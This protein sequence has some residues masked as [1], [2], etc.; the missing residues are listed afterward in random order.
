MADVPAI[1]RQ[2]KVWRQRYARERTKVLRRLIRRFNSGHVH[3]G[4]VMIEE[5]LMSFG[6]QC[7]KKGNSYR[8]YVDDAVVSTLYPL[9]RTID[10]ILR[11]DCDCTALPGGKW[12]FC[13]RE[14]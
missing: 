1:K 13:V 12:F 10:F 5:I 14:R 2:M 11:Y 9:T 6:L 3:Y 7:E 8:F 4:G